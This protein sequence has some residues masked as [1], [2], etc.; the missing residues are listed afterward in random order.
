MC[1]WTNEHLFC[2][3]HCVVVVVVVYIYM[4]A[5]LQCA[6]LVVKQSTHIILDE[7]ILHILID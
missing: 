7:M 5:D 1:T 2:N 6:C 4:L 3:L